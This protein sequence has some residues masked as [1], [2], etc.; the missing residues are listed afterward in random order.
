MAA[1]DLF[2]VIALVIG[3][4]IT[5]EMLGARFAVPNF[6]FFGIAG[7]VLGPPGLQ[8]V[9]H[10]VFGEGLSVIVGLGVAIII[11]HS[12]SDIHIETIR[13][14]PRMAYLLAT[15]GTLVT[16]LGS[17]A[18]TYLI[19]DVSPGIALLIGA[20]L[21]PTGTTV[22]EPLLAAVALPDRLA[23]P[24]EIEALVTEVTAGI[25]AISVFY[26]VTLTETNPD[27]FLFVFVWHLLAGVLVGGL[28]GGSAL[29]LFTYPE[30]APD[31]APEHASQL[32][33]ATAIVAFSVAENVAREAGV[34][35][36]ATAGLLLGN[37]DL[38]YKDHITDFEDDFVT[39]VLA[40]MFVILASFVEPDWLR[41]VGLDG[42]LVAVGVIVL[43]RP[44]AVFLSATGSVL[45]IREKLFLST[46]SPRGIIPAGLATLLA[47]DIQDTFP[48]AAANITG[49]V[50]LVIL[51]T[52]L[53]EG[54][55]AGRVADWLDVTADAVVIVG[56]GGMGLALADQYEERGERV[57]VI[58]SDMDAVETGRSLGLTVYH[59][60]GTDETV[61]REAQADDATRIVAATDDD[62]VNREVARLSESLGVE[63]VLV[64]L[65]QGNDRA[66]FEDLDVELLTGSQLDIWALGQ[67][68]DQSVP[69]WLTELTRTGGVGTASVADEHV[70]S[71]V[72]DLGGVL[73]ERSFVV[74][75][76]R[77]GD[78][79]IP[80]STESFE[81]GD[82]VTVLGRS[83]AVDGAIAA[84][85]PELHRDGDTLETRIDATDGERR[86]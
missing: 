49:T 64:R 9:D 84:I 8:V 4:A 10:Q 18:V 74:T 54:V 28:V 45:S 42:L 67:F 17:A 12:G 76:T 25:M 40:F 73:P 43:V 14:A 80:E 44:L 46:I 19:L 50:L 47:I 70:G 39:F 3:L 63:T 27:Q 36:V 11:F 26:G 38:P 66:M 34:A 68:V 51:L 53:V 35:A 2:A 30:H 31:K 71:T 22:I 69:D 15:V 55:F 29:F 41:T 23:N 16:F 61:L 59:G 75:L 56:G 33:L 24:L 60:D 13:N 52:T 21:I 79:W 57:N 62:E 65:N 82:R 78:T 77:D 85:D 48:E 5:A 1:T 81:D 58:E 32:F 7:I 6:L 37:A 72:A 20:L 86:K 83:D